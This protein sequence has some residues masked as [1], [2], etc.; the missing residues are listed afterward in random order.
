MTFSADPPVRPPGPRPTCACVAE[1]QAGRKPHTPVLHGEQQD[2]HCGAWLRLCDRIEE[3]IASGQKEFAPLDGMTGEERSQIVTL[4]PRIGR[5]VQVQKLV[6][7][8]SH[9]VRVPSEIGGMQSLANLD[10]YTSYRLHFLPYEVTRCAQLRRSRASTRA[11]FG[12]YKHRSPFPDLTHDDNKSALS[13]LKPSTCSVCS[14]LLV[15][16]VS[17]RWL[18]LA[19]GTD[20]FPLLVNACSQSCVDA[21]PE[22]AEGYIAHPHTGGGRLEQPPARC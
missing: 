19:I 14:A 16:P 13:L 21:L 3:A 11:L 22:G 9:L 8:G 2:V 20:W 10:I 4:P 7:Y 12:N 1:P 18:T 15:G 5:L 17:V 6:L